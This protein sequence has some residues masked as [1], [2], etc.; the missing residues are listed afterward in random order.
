MEMLIVGFTL[1]A[2]PSGM[3]FNENNGQAC[4]YFAV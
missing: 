2:L 4:I 1:V 3:I